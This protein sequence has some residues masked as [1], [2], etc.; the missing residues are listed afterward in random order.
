MNAIGQTPKS[1]PLIYV[2]WHE[3]PSTNVKSLHII[4]EKAFDNRIQHHSQG[5][6]V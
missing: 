5:L 1:I 6:D 4:A 2:A 3:V